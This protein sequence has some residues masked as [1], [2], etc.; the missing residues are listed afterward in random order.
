MHSSLVQ[1]VRLPVLHLFALAVPAESHIGPLVKGGGVT[2]WVTGYGLAITRR[3]PLRLLVAAEP[4][5]HYN[6]G[7]A[8][9]LAH[10]N[11]TA[12]ASCMS[13]SRAIALL[14]CMPASEVAVCMHARRCKAGGLR[15]AGVD[16]ARPDRSASATRSQ[17][18]IRLDRQGPSL[19]QS[20]SVWCPVESRHPPA[21]AYSL[22]PSS[23][24]QPEPAMATSACARYRCC[25]AARIM[26]DGDKACGPRARAKQ[27]RR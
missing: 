1:L 4:A 18:E 24:S 19:V 5:F 27:E 23:S 22:Q 21:P 12:Q 25:A 8:L 16:R 26:R 9:C 11:R 6:Y 17:S 14:L 15:L 13:A 2:G 20:E 7:F 10:H 3:N